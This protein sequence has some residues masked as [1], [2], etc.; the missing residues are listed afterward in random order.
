MNQYIEYVVDRLVVSFGYSKIYK[1]TN[2]FGFIE[3]IGM[4]QKTN[5]YQEHHMYTTPMVIVWIIP[6]VKT[7]KNGKAYIAITINFY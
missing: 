7:V 6:T 4:I 5:W 2:P 1:S 3:T